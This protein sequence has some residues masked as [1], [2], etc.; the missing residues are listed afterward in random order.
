MTPQTVPRSPQN[1]PPEMP[2]VKTIIHALILAVSSEL[3]RSSAARKMLSPEVVTTTS[4]S[5]LACFSAQFWICS[6][7]AR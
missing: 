7:P 3:A 2:R 6:D 1:G 5:P 4:S